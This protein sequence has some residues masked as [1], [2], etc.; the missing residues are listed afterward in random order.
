[1]LDEQVIAQAIKAL[2]AEPLHSH[3]VREQPKTVLELYDQFAKFSKSEV[4][5]FSSSSSKEKFQNQMKLR[6]VPTTTISAI[7]RGP[8]TTSVSMAAYLQRIGA[9]IL[10][11]HHS[12][13][14]LG[15]SIRDTQYNQRGVGSNRGRGR[16]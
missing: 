13:E 10:G 14:I 7:T 15:P 12:K 6:K 1:V 9:K 5:H 2:R 16:S 3:L 4:Q 11:D 8:Y